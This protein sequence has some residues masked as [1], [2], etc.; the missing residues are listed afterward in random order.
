V[1]CKLTRL[2]SL[3]AVGGVLAS[4]GGVQGKLRTQASYDLNCPRGELRIK[5]VAD[6]TMSVE[7]CGVGRT[8]M[9]QCLG[10]KGT[11]EYKCEWVMDSDVRR[12]K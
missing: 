9:E 1:S 8:Y 10:A 3:L 6:H 11:P 4:C 7:G 12:E 2:L 5:K